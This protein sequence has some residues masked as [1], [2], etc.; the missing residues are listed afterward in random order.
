MAIPLFLI[1]VGY[2][3]GVLLP[4]CF[5]ARPRIQ[6][7]IAHGLAAV[8]T[9]GGIYLGMVGLLAPEPLAMSVP[10]T[11]PLLTFAVR[12]DALSSF[13]LLMISLVGLAASI[14]AVGY[15]TE[16]YGRI[17]IGL[18]GSLYN[19][20]LLSMTLVVLADNGFFFLIAWELMSLFSYFLVV[21]EHE[22]SDVRYAGLFYLIM[23]HIGTAFIILTFLLLFQGSG[24][25]SFDA[26][27]DP[28]HPLPDNMRTM[29]FVLA[30]IG[31]GTKAGIV[32]LHVWLPY[33]HPA[34]PSHISALM[35]GVMIKTAIY[36]LLRVYFDFF[37]GHFPWWWG[38]VVLLIG[39]VSALLGV[40]YALMEHDL[41]SLLAY[42]SVENIGIILLGIGAGM[43]FH[44][45]G[46]DEL[47]ALG[48]IAG[49]YHTINHAVF[50]AL[51]FFGAGSLLYAT[52]TRNMEEYGG[53]LRRMP[54]TGACFLIGAVSIAALPPTNGFVS[55]WLVFQ[56]LFL[57][58]QMPSL[59]MKFMLPLAAAMLALTGVL[60]LTCF[61][62]AFG[63]SFLALPRSSHARHAE[64]VPWPMRVGMGVLSTVCIALGLA[65]M[66]VIPFLDHVS[67]S[68][69]GRSI[70]DKML[71]LD[72]WA[73][74]P[75]NVEFSSLSSPVL[76][77]LL[78]ATAAL[79]LALVVC[80][81]GTS[82]RRYSK[83][84]ACGLN[85]TS[86]MEYSATGFVQPIKRVFST[87]YQPTVKLETEFLEESRYFAKRRR[88]EFHIEPL[89]QTYFYDPLIAFVSGLADRMRIVQAGSLH[90][91]LAYIFVTLVVLLM[92]AL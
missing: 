81:G 8:A 55:E 66:L 34:A 84:W 33:A 2:A 48:L 11:L 77:F 21:T 4:L 32:P 72:G 23:T 18:L 26:F 24:S 28:G 90:L 54:W 88:F 70:A 37:G 40:M 71:A 25:F 15:V 92:V 75:V 61:A 89:F 63:I 83:T 87:I 39:A 41:K 46:L 6:N 82:P 22:K 44:S 30:L 68:L 27:R 10:S 12:L 53:L 74:A 67:T 79:G 9:M 50:K 49:L 52:H 1:L 65:P 64:E 5:P 13:F 19:A 45:Y 59:L 14:Y 3:A 57:S 80:Y 73:L 43:I 31:F 29:A 47:A 38:F 7:L 69:I 60:A 35:S 17:S 20:F 58:Y 85:L 56:S 51:L 76:G 78:V 42:H 62:K 36:A 16:W 86:R 91:Y